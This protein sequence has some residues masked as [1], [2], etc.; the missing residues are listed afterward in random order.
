M[1]NKERKEKYIIA[2]EEQIKALGIVIWERKRMIIDELPLRSQRRFSEMSKNNE[3]MQKRNGL[4]SEWEK[5][6]GK[7]WEDIPGYRTYYP[8]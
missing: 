5:I 6:T 8:E 2:L 7:R 4:I 1:H 3:S